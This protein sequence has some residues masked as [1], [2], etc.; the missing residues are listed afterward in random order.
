MEGEKQSFE[1][2]MSRIAKGLDTHTVFGEPEMLDGS[3]IIPVAKIGYGGGGGSGTGQAKPGGE[4]GAEMG[5][6][7]GEGTGM[8]FGVTAK[9]LGVIEVK[10]DSVRWIPVIDTNR[11]IAIWS[12]LGGLAIVLLARAIG[13][14]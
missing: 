9:P 12:V 2:V 5:A 1:S 13:R 10:H 6:G 4:T 7:T 11:I 3:A 8:G 14:R